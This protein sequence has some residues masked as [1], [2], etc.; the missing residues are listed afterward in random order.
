M[1]QEKYSIA[2]ILDIAA[3]THLKKEKIA[4]LRKHDSMP[5]RNI[6]AGMYDSKRLKPMLPSDE[7]PYKPNP[8]RQAY[9]VLFRE[10]RKLKYFF[11]GYSSGNITT[12]KREA[13][14]IEMLENVR[15]DDAKLLIRMIQQKPIKGLT[16]E[17]I[18]EAYGE[19]ITG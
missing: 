16:K 14:F 18:N 5:V 7:P 6:L 10:S 1:S 8:N 9:A 15:E 3:N 2:E 13:L 11:E 12:I 19:I 4:F 17:V